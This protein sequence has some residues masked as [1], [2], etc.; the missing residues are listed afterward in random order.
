MQICRNSS[1]PGYPVRSLCT[2]Y[3]E[4]ITHDY[5]G[6]HG[7]IPARDD[8]ILL[9]ETA[10]GHRLE[11]IIAVGA[12]NSLEIAKISPQ[13]LGGRIRFEFSQCFHDERGGIPGIGGGAVR[14][15]V[16]AL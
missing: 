2:G 12:G 11:I 1:T 3:A 9:V 15:D 6:L 8:D 16:S 10:V 5:P 4:R 13:I 7:R 14:L